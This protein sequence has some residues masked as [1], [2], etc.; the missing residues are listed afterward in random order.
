MA[1]TTAAGMIDHLVG[2]YGLTDATG[3]LTALRWLQLAE[4]ECWALEDWWFKRKR[5][6]LPL[7]AG[8]KVYSLSESV[9]RVHTVETGDGGSLTE[10]HPSYFRRI[11]QDD[12]TADVVQ[13]WCRL[14]D[15]TT[16]R[17]TLEFWPVPVANATL[18]ALC[19]LAVTVLEDDDASVSGF[20]VEWRHVV[21]LK[22]EVSG[23]LHVGQAG[24]AEGF[25]REWGT[26][27]GA[28]SALN[29]KE[30]EN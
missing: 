11:V 14:E 28:L 21:L 18:K 9:N 20:P 2:R 29:K 26:Q 13:I 5:V 3:R 27:M 19:D 12:A 16:R 7:V 22:A 6:D 24:Q 1:T 4:E 17:P 10:L 25:T 23:S 8:T 30:A 15:S